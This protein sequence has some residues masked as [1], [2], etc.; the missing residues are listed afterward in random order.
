LSRVS[1]RLC[2]RLLRWSWNRR[3]GRASFQPIF[4]PRGKI[5]AE[6]HTAVASGW[7]APGGRVLDIGCGSGWVARWL[8]AR[9]YRVL[10]IDYAAGAIARAAAGDPAEG[11]DWK[12]VDIVNDPPPGTDFDAVLDRGCLHVI[13]QPY[14]PAYA[15]TARACAKPGA[16]FLLLMAKAHTRGGSFQPR[17]KAGELQTQVEHIFAPLFTIDRVTETEILTVAEDTL[18]A[19]P[20]LAFWMTAR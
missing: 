9:G 5:P 7:F 2:H 13:A 11:L 1:P 20:G 12:V 10:G 6:V 17:P 8:A 18:Q 14:W 4:E 15:K 3:W 19:L 16:H